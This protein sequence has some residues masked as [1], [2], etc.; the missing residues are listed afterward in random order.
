MMGDNQ[1]IE[2]ILG[3]LVEL[4]VEKKGQD[5]SSSDVTL[6]GAEEVHKVELMQNDIKLEGVKNYLC[7]SRRALLILRTKGLEGYVTGKIEMPKIKSTNEW[8]NWNVTNSLVVWLLNSLSPAIAVTVET[9]SSA[10]E[11]WEVLENV[12]SGKDNVMLMVQTQERISE[13]Q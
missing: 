2:Q 10:V 6:P 12:Y 9:I 8:K 7:W 11:I 13:L 3:K 4:L 1:G 5:S